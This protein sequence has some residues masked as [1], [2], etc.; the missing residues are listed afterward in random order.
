MKKAVLILLS[1]IFFAA[2][3]AFGVYDAVSRL[4]DE[5]KYEEAVKL[6]SAEIIKD[7][8]NI[9]FRNLRGSIYVD[10]LKIPEKGIDDFSFLIKVAEKNKDYRNA[11]A[12][13]YNR[14]NAYFGSKKYEEAIEDYS[15][16]IVLRDNY[17]YYYNRASAYFFL[18]MY[19][20]AL[21]DMDSAIELNPDFASSYDNRG[22][23]RLKKHEYEEAAKDFERA[24]LLT[25]KKSLIYYNLTET[26]LYTGNFQKALGYLQEYIK[27]EKSAYIFNDDYILWGSLLDKG[28]GTVENDK[29]IAEIRKIMDLNLLKKQ[30]Q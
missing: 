27:E 21:N 28:A 6:L 14:G 26:Y 19:D 13:Y 10:N 17:S 20:E 18:N 30:R 25:N 8:D 5:N 16:A 4:R 1:V 15:R 22:V 29:Y 12:G 11:A 3:S 24:L 9:S 23:L 2:Q 7:P